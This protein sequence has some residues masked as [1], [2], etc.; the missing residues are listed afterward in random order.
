MQIGMKLVCSLLL[1]VVSTTL[2]AQM[3]GWL[4]ELNAEIAMMEENIASCRADIE[5]FQQEIDDLIKNTP[6]PITGTATEK[7]I[8]ELQKMRS[9]WRCWAEGAE[10][11]LRRIKEI[12]DELKKYLGS[13]SA[14]S[15]E[16][17]M[18]NQTKDKVNQAEKHVKEMQAKGQKLG[19][20]INKA[21]G[22][23]R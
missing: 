18:I 7:R 22:E 21:L 2:Y 4:T 16:Q 8:R 3:P 1:L 5:D 10:K 6:P 15:S 20:T 19:D 23:D 17:R 9:L 14:S 11:K 13:G 12:R